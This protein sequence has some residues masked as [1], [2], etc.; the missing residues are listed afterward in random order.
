MIQRRWWIA[1]L[2]AVSLTAM[3]GPLS[4][5][6][7]PSFALPD[8]Q[9]RY[10]DILDYRGKP[11]LLE[12]MQ[13]SCPHCQ[14]LAVTLERVRTKYGAQVGVLSI[15]N[16]PDTQATVSEFIRKYKVD[17]PLLFDSGQATAA[18]MKVTPQNPRITLPHLFLIDAA[19]N[20]QED[21][22]YEESTKAIFEGDA[23]FGHV[24]RLLSSGKR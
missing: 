21:W 17:Y 11:L 12:V 7:V 3:A 22:A 18:L 24:D 9:L 16:P 15:V 8:G 4:G 5:R 19:G 20:I 23:L 14:S 2:C 1:I 10:H 6:R 13:T